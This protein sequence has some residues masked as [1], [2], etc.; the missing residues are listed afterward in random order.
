MICGVSSSYKPVCPMKS[1]SLYDATAM[2]SY[3]RSASKSRP[4]E[5]VGS[6][7]IALFFWLSDDRNK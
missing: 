2:A 3:G 5:L 6:E 4:F 7:I 1:L